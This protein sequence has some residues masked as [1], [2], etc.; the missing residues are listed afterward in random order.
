MSW[1]TFKC[2]Q[3]EAPSMEGVRTK[4]RNIMV[5]GDEI[6]MNCGVCTTVVRPDGDT[7]ILFQLKILPQLK[8]SILSIF[9]IIGWMNKCICSIKG[10]AKEIRKQVKDW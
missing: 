6:W 5:Y 8:I 9:Y 7:P 4:E 1:E 3:T 10:N 2:Y